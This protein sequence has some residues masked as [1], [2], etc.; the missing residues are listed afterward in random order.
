MFS[1]TKVASIVA[2]G[3]LSFAGPGV[4][5]LPDENCE[6][7]DYIHAAGEGSES[8]GFPFCASKYKEGI[9]VK[10]LEVQADHNGVR[11]MIVTFTDNSYEQAGHMEFEDVDHSLRQKAEFDPLVDTVTKAEIWANGNN[12]NDGRAVGRFVFETS[13]G[14]KIDVGH[15]DTDGVEPNRL[16]IGRSGMLMGVGGRSGA[17]IDR[18][19]LLFASDPIKKRSVEDMEISP[20]IEEINFRQ[21]NSERGFVVEY[22]DE[23]HHVNNLS[24]TTE[25]W[26]RGEKHVTE[27]TSISKTSSDTFHLG[28]GF[29]FTTKVGIPFIASG[30]LTTKTDMFWEH[31]EERT[32]TETSSTEI[33]KAWQQIAN[34][35]PF[36]AIRCYAWTFEGSTTEITWEG[37]I[38]IVFENDAVL[39]Y[40]AKG[41]YNTA[42]YSRVNTF[43]KEESIADAEAAARKGAKVYENGKRIMSRGIGERSK[44][45]AKR[46]GDKAGQPRRV[47]DGPR[48]EPWA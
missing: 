36:T 41:D 26:L 48:T 11:G 23:V 37:K 42:Q 32:S 24:S 16:D 46:K 20:T 7:T 43:C 12:H 17:N 33:V 45:K 35:E 40:P 1:F 15:G 8:G 2:V 34:A 10:S 3:F 13:N 47:T 27:T 39:E 18:I 19:E 9:L 25:I 6:R 31:K 4:L 30:E 22:L 38:R 21:T 5:A 28:L 29:E 44:A 14:G